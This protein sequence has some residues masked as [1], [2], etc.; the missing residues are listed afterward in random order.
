MERVLGEKVAISVGT[1]IAIEKIIEGGVGREF[2]N[3]YFNLKT[4]FRN[5]HDSIKD[6]SKMDMKVVKSE[7][8]KE[9][10]TIVAI[11]QD[12][13]DG[14]L[15][16]VIYYMSYSSAMR[17]MKYAKFKKPSTKNQLAYVAA[18]KEVLTWLFKQK[19]ASTIAKLDSS[20]NGGNIRALI[21]THLPIDLLSDLSFRNLV[22]VESYTGELKDKLK[23]GTKL[24]NPEKY[25]H[26]PFCAL[27][28]QVVGDG[29]NLFT[30]GGRK[31]TDTLMEIA[32]K[33][34]WHQATKLMKIRYDLGKWKDRYTA[35][36]LTEMAMVKLK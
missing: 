23:W 4:L 34:N 7:F 33:N 25:G 17:N 15:S 21:L 35:A 32:E 22:L 18:E 11:T 26:L 20:I 19:F 1:A 5:F 2:D 36:I 14:N 6:T 3:I 8:L 10:E 30:S 29:S 9:L 13:I 24:T 12:V 31:F 28:I 16:P 27:T